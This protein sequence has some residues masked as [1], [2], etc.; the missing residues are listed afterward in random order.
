[1]KLSKTFPAL[2][3]ALLFWGASLWAQTP[4]NY[5][6]NG[7][8]S[9][10]SVQKGDYFL[11]NYSFRDHHYQPRQVVLNMPV[12]QTQHMV[13]RFGIPKEMLQP[14]M[15]TEEVIRLREQIMREG[16]F[17]AGSRVITADLSAVT[18]Y[19]RP[20]CEQIAI[21]L[22]QQLAIEGTDSRRNRIEL[23][24]KFVQDIPYGVPN[25]DE[26]ERYF[27]GLLTPP[28]VMLYRYG[29]CDSKSVLFAGILSFMI[30][31]DDI[32]FL[33]CP[34]HVLTGISGQ[35]EKGQFYVIGLEDGK[36]YILAET[37]G[38]GR[39]GWGNP[40]TN[41]QS[42]K[43]YRIER[44]V[45]NE[46]SDAEWAVG[47]R[48]YY[49]S[50]GGQSIT[51]RL[52]NAW[53]GDHLLVFDTETQHTYLLEQFRD[54]RD[55]DSHPAKY[56]IGPAFWMRQNNQFY[57]FVN[58]QSVGHRTLTEWDGNDVLIKDTGTGQRYRLPNFKHTPEGVVTTAY[59]D[60]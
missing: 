47:E 41:F 40:G 53:A 44:L 18:S 8:V 20:Y 22:L 34:D 52:K 9:M 39:V 56:L 29:D 19:Y 60:I 46:R 24:M 12:E 45:L 59:L 21:Q 38:P 51:D 11:V 6:R 5:Q 26:S 30:D 14:Y 43:Q 17:A 57:F 25:L 48:G 36:K 33:R 4:K 42:G 58:G 2:L 50:I 49:F 16:M 37:A 23:A 27:G 13:S 3:G 31:P 54:R 15:A 10:E 1:M 35:P 32:V 55:R 7:H 28:E